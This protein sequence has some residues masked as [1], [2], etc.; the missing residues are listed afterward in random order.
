MSAGHGKIILPENEYWRI[1]FWEVLG[2]GER[3]FRE[4][5][6]GRRMLRRVFLGG[7]LLWLAFM[8][9][10]YGVIENGLLPRN[11]GSGGMDS[12]LPCWLAWLLIQSFHAQRLGIF[13]LAFGLLGFLSGLR[14]CAWVGWLVGVAGLVLYSPDYAAVGALL[15][16]FTLL[17]IYTPAA[18]QGHG[19]AL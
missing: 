19:I 1:A 12:S 11:C 14:L 4:T 8:A 16:L 5:E 9:L 3:G 6:N 2:V 13:A 17:R 7:G 15:G 18:P 10:R